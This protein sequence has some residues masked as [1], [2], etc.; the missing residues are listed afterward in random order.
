M[1]ELEAL[2]EAIYAAPH[3]DAPRLVYADAVLE[4]GDPRG[5]FIV[6]QCH[7]DAA[8]DLVLRYGD[9]WLGKLAP[10]LSASTFE[11]GFLAKATVQLP[12]WARDANAVVG[13]PALRTVRELRGPAIVAIHPSMTALRILHVV[14]DRHQPQAWRELLAGTPRDLTELHYEPVIDGGPT[15]T[16]MGGGT[17]TLRV[18]ADELAALAACAALPKLR[19]LVLHN[20]PDTSLGFVF[21][22]G[23]LDRVPIVESH[24]GPITVKVAGG[25]AAITLAP[26][27]S[28]HSA[29]LILAFVRRLPPQVGIELTTGPR[30]DRA[31]IERVLGDRLRR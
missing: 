10:Y 30:F 27:A 6:R 24:H 5:E 29:E 11:R 3:D 4:Q 1:T 18:S 16:P 28:P 19:R 13:H 21:G 8:S 12:T 23:L 25:I 15:A 31:W 7:G 20:V 17:W 2:L 14:P 26:S 22:E 9:A